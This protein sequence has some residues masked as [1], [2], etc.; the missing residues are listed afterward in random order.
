MPSSAKA[1]EAA[2]ARDEFLRMRPTIFEHWDEEMA[3]RNYRPED[4]AH[5]AEGARKAGFPVTQPDG[6]GRGAPGGHA[7]ADP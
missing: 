6:R 7:S 4:G 1:S 2:E 5:L 3:K